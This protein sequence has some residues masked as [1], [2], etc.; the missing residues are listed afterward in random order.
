MFWSQFPIQLF[1]NPKDR[2]SRVPVA[3]KGKHEFCFYEVY[4]EK[5]FSSP[6][7][8]DG[9]NLHDG[10][11][12]PAISESKKVLVSASDSA[13]FINFK[14]IMCGFSGF[15][16]NL[17]WKVDISGRE[18]TGIDIIVKCLFRKHDF[19]RIAGTDVMNGLSFA[20]QRG[21]KSIQLKSFRFR[22]RNARAGFG[23][24]K[25]VFLLSIRGGIEMFFESTVTAFTAAIT[26]IRR[27]G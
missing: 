1:K 23:E 21:D 24:D 13:G 9:I 27:L 25:F 18:H 14:G 15:V 16:R 20:D 8:F 6:V 22:N 2:S 7:A 17:T 19:R 26:N 4:G 12:Y 10:T 11:V 5:D 3:D